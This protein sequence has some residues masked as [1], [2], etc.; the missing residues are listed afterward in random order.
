MTQNSFKVLTANIAGQEWMGWSK[1]KDVVCKIL[2]KIDTDIIGFQEFGAVGNFELLKN[3]LPDFG[4][5]LGIKLSN[6]DGD[7]YINTCAFRKKRFELIYN[8][9]FWSSKTGQFIKDEPDARG[10]RGISYCV[11]FDKHTK[12]ELLLVNFH[13]DNISANARKHNIKIV[14]DFANQDLYKDIPT[15]LTADSNMSVSS[16]NPR[17][18][19]E[20]MI[21]PYYD[22]LCANFYDVWTEIHQERRRT[23]HAFKGDRYQIDEWGTWD[24]ELIMSRGL[25]PIHAA[26]IK[27]SIDGI[28][29]SDHFFMQA[30]LSFI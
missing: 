14:I 20:E 5:A 26:L 15:V 22:L 17:W 9:T 25:R 27:Q 12:R 13:P 19:T 24:T 4:F 29:P 23:Y 28:Y 30:E 16:P 11:F 10:I 18:Q 3:A 2:S 7:I 1:R 6:S 8:G 21:R